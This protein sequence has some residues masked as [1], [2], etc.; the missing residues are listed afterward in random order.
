MTG[1]GLPPSELP[2]KVS[3]FECTVRKVPLV[4]HKDAGPVVEAGCCALSGFT[5]IQS[6]LFD[7]AEVVGVKILLNDWKCRVN[8]VY[9]FV[10]QWCAAS[11]GDRTAC[12]LAAA[13]VAGKLR[14]GNRFLHDCFLDEEHNVLVR[15][16]MLE[17]VCS[18]TNF[19]QRQKVS[20]N[21]SSKR[22][23]R[24][25]GVLTI[26]FSHRI[27]PEI[28]CS[29]LRLPCIILLSGQRPNNIFL[30]KLS[31]RINS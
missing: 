18:I 2:P 22:A 1:E 30:T 16:T 28:V 11:A 27:F 7:G 17:V 15:S 21:R 13:K 24:M 19:C 20:R 8:L 5:L 9:F 26:L 12:P 3:R 10:E 31:Y 29:V 25:A 23:A 14:R 6:L 4:G